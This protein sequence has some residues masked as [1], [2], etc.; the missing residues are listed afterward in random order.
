MRWFRRDRSRK[1]R[2][3]EM[4]G[5]PIRNPKR[6]PVAKL[7]DL[8]VKITNGTT[9]KGGSKVYVD[10]GVMFL[11][12][13]NVWKGRLE[14]E[15]VAFLDVETNAKQKDS[16]LKNGDLLITKT[17][18]VNTENSSLGRTAIYDGPDGRANIN[19]HVYLVRLKAGVPRLYVLS[20]LISD[21]YRDHIRSVC[22]G[23]IDKR[24]LNLCHIENFPI[25][26]PPL[27]L[28]REFAAFVAKVDKSK[29]AVRKS[30]ESYQKLY[31]QQLQEAFG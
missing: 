1:S 7:S 20:I 28:Q 6:L 14:L 13:Q 21:S 9:P 19:G 3:V 26:Q 18:R 31:R 16:C 10:Q 17:G 30:L 12:S 27:A 2:F 24:Q 8:A 23:G 25:L 5:D 11:R 4:F 29:F 15:G 22:V